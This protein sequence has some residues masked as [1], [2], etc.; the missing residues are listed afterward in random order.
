[1]RTI[2]ATTHYVNKRRA[3]NRR[4]VKSKGQWYCILGSRR[5]EALGP[6]LTHQV[7]SIKFKSYML[8]TKSLVE[9]FKLESEPQKVLG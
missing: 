1:M 7:D 3:P 5:F 6:L 9:T 8:E 4:L 2:V